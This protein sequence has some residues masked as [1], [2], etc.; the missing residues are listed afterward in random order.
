M[1]RPA[2]AHQN[3]AEKNMCKQSEFFHQH[4]YTE[5][6]TWKQRGFL[7]QRNYIEKECGNDVV[8][9]WKFVEI[10]PSTYQWNNDVES[11]SIRRGAPVGQVVLKVFDI[12]LTITSQL[13]GGSLKG[14][15]SNKR[16]FTLPLRMTGILVWMIGKFPSLIKQIV[17]EESRFG[18]V[19][20]WATQDTF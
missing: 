20:K 7:D 19:E 14:I 8:T 3:F 6:S 4:N 9:T 16:Y 18:V 17:G 15:P 11:T 1:R 12:H 10:F 5:K 2:F 13:I